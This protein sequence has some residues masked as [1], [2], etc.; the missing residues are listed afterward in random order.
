MLLF[1]DLIQLLE[2]GIKAS[3]H[4]VCWLITTWPC[5]NAINAITSDALVDVQ[6]CNVRPLIKQAPLQETL[7][8]F[9]CKL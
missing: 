7:I 3:H 4:L 9:I 8:C 1:L 2:E 6:P 5:G